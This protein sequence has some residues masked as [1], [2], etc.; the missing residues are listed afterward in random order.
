MRTEPVTIERIDALLA[1]LPIFEASGFEPIQATGGG[2]KQPDGSITMAYPIY[3][4]PVTDF[5]HLAGQACW[6]DYGYQA[7]TAGAMLAD[8]ARLA[9]CGLDDIKTMLTYCV[10]G[11]RFSDGLWDHLIRTG[12]VSALLRRLAKLRQTLTESG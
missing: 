12:R 5:F 10:R 7:R 11:E 8:D 9:T 6:C 1:F 2:Q 4:D 3:A